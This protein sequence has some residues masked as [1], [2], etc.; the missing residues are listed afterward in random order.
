MRVVGIA[1][2]DQS[3]NAGCFIA[4]VAVDTFRTYLYGRR[5]L[6]RQQCHVVRVEY[7]NFISHLQTRFAQLQ[8][9]VTVQV[10]HDFTL[11]NR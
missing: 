8:Q 5:L 6:Q 3:R 10:F 4:Q 1:S 7:C 11:I 2:Y 9:Y